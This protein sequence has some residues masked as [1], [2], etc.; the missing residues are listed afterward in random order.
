MFNGSVHGK[1]GGNSIPDPLEKPY[2]G[3]FCEVVSHIE[4]EKEKALN[5]E[6]TISYLS[7][8]DYK[9]PEN[10]VGC[11]NPDSEIL[12][13]I[14]L[15]SKYDGIGNRNCA[16]DLVIA[17]DISGSMSAKIENG[18]RL[19]L[20]KYITFMMKDKLKENDRLSVLSFENHAESLFN[21]TFP[22]QINETHLNSV[23]ILMPTGGTVISS[24]IK[25]V[26]KQFE[27]TAEPIRQRRLLLLTDMDNTGNDEELIS[28]ILNLSSVF[29]VFTSVVGIGE[30]PDIL[31]TEKV[32]KAKGFNYVTAVNTIEAN[33][34]INNFEM[35]FF[36]I[37]TDINLTIESGDIEVK[38]VY[39]TNFNNSVLEL[40][41]QMF[42]LKDTGLYSPIIK[43]SILTLLYTYKMH[44]KRTP[45][46]VISC[47]LD[48]LNYKKKV[49]NVCE[50]SACTATSKL[51]P[52]TQKGKF[53][54]V[55]C[56][57]KDSKLLRKQNVKIKCDFEL[58][59]KTF[60]GD[61][62]KPGESPYSI[63]SIRKRVEYLIV[64]TDYA[65][66]NLKMKN[67]I[68]MFFYNKFFRD[69]CRNYYRL[70]LSIDYNK[71]KRN[72]KLFRGSPLRNFLHDPKFLNL[73]PSNSHGS[74]EIEQITT[75]N[76]ELQDLKNPVEIE[77][78][79][80]ETDPKM[81]KAKE[82]LKE[83]NLTRITSKLKKLFDDH[84]ENPDSTIVET[85]FSGLQTLK[86]NVKKDKAN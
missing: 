44:G 20:A 12:V 61:N 78:I 47:F 4:E 13:G 52:T 65:Q 11:Q 15:K 51:G 69:V 71:G 18:N 81:I 80:E 38:K 21:L 75:T 36:P 5:F 45:K 41:N 59:Y 84:Y 25:E 9:L 53:F 10:T 39:G 57:L 14:S 67:G 6:A 24:V 66:L 60:T 54:I 50:I 49:K 1:F 8:S 16:L 30:K 79:K 31:L 62:T 28:G 29:S 73:S 35:N 33:N 70:D 48:F 55:V 76:N 27:P 74:V 68:C 46:P 7:R 40:Q 86:E 83:E 17:I 56:G 26:M 43:S 85:I 72:F 82:F 32:S 64:N 19:D 58:S 3:A 34:F 23:N 77:A 42:G 2:L 37:A 63:E 22:S